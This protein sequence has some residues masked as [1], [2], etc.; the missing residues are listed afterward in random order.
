MM[1]YAIFYFVLIYIGKHKFPFY[2]HHKPVCLH[3]AWCWF[4][5]YLRKPLYRLVDRPVQQ[6]IIKKYYKNYFFV[7]LQL[8]NDAQVTNHSNYTD[9]LDFIE[10]ILVSFARYAPE[11]KRLVIKQHPFD[12]GHRQ[13]KKFIQKRCKALNIQKRV[14][15]VHE[16]NVAKCLRYSCGSVVINSTVGL[17][18]LLHN[19]PVKVMGFACYDI[20]GLTYQG[21]L[22]NFW[23]NP[24]K[25]S[26]ENYNIFRN[27]VLQTTQIEGSFYS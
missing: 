6:R 19:I 16:V 7:P 22:S 9:I 25:V 5:S 23:N 17:S 11:D 14:Y 21:C 24:G 20:G 15:Y 2:K 4:I 18:A 27:Y 10:D 3:D 26:S 13:Y 1:F 8:Y 12:R